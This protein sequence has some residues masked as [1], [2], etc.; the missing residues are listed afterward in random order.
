[1]M[2]NLYLYLKTNKEISYLKV[3]MI[4]KTVVGGTFQLTW[5][6]KFGT[7]VL[8]HTSSQIINLKLNFAAL[9]ADLEDDLTL[10]I[11]P[12]FEVIIANLIKEK[13]HYGF[14]PFVNLLPKLLAED[15]TLHQ[16]L[17][18][19]KDEVSEDVLETIIV[20]LEMNMSVN[21]VAR[22][23]YTH[24]N[25]VNYR[26]TRFIELSGIDIRSTLNGYYVYLL[27]SWDNPVYNKKFF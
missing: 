10:V 4:L 2:N 22:S 26:I 5:D 16:R 17:L 1:M 9:C 25:T 18:S 20:Y 11:V 13:G 14:Y 24:R 15:P 7:I 21:M 12:R 6:G 3:E 19:F 27:I 23:V 8:E